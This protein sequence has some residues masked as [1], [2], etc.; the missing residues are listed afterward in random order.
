MAD[1]IQLAFGI[2]PGFMGIDQADG[3]GNCHD[4]RK[5]SH[6]PMSNAAGLETNYA[7]GS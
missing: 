2:R 1:I 3:I 5:L 6:L 7:A 4:E